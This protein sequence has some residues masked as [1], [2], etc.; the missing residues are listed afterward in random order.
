[1][2]EC[3]KAEN[4]VEMR[5]FVFFVCIPVNGREGHYGAEES[6][7]FQAESGLKMENLAITS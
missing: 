2:K 3:I 1:M 4:T 5:D 7:L 6:Y